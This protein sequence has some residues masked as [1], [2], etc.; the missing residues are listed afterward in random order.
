MF[1]VWND[2]AEPSPTDAQ[3]PVV[4]DALPSERGTDQL[5]LIVRLQGTRGTV[6]HHRLSGC[7]DWHRREKVKWTK[8]ASW[9]CRGGGLSSGDVLVVVELD[10][11]IAQATEQCWSEISA[12]GNQVALAGP[13]QRLSQLR[14][15]ETSRET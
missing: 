6:I 14:G 3:E 10:A 13:L 2:T 1:G 9:F 12:C 4:S 7:A 15:L 8:P 11:L 5:G